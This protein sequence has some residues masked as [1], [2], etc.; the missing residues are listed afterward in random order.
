MTANG[1]SATAGTGWVV[2]PQVGYGTPPPPAADAEVGAMAAAVGLAVL[3]VA[4][5]AWL[6]PATPKAASFR[7]R[8]PYRR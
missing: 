2:R 8:T 6:L 4:A 3:G 7:N 5:A 1:A